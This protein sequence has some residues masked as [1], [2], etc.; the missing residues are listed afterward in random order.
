[1]NK[2]R[3]FLKMAALSVLSFFGYKP[4]VK[5]NSENNPEGLP[6]LLFKDGIAHEGMIYGKVNLKMWQYKEYVASTPESKKLYNRR[7][8][9]YVRTT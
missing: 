3:N 1:M 8:I 2:R 4:E 7:W 9:K 5:A 6:V